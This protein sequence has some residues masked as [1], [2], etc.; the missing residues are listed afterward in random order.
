MCATCNG[1]ECKRG[2]AW[3]CGEREYALQK[4]RNTSALLTDKKE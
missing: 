2:E 1:N 4:K 3:R